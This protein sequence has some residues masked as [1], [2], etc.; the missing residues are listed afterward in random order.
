MRT[1]FYVAD[2]TS[3]LYTLDPATGSAA[4]V[5]PCGITDVT[6]L[7]FHGPTLYGISFSQLLRL[8]PETGAATVI[9]ATGF[10]TN[11]LVVSEEG[12]IYAGTNPGQL[13]S[14]NPVT[15]A[16]TLIGDFGGG[17]TSAGDLVIDANG[18]MYGALNSGSEVVL[19]RIDRNTGAATVIGPIG[20]S[21]IYGLA[22]GC[23]HMYGFAFSGNVLAINVSTGTGTVIGSSGVGIGGATARACCCC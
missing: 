22:I 9:G 13:I 20:F 14:I 8:N 6:D 17:L 5:G 23:C 1:N 15:G 10:T 18:V 16:G 3:S 11:G 2:L 7:A 19:A 4:L 12:I 21:D